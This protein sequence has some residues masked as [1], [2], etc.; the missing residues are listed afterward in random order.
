MPLMIDI[1]IGW[2]KKRVCIRSDI[3]WFGINTVSIN[4][5]LQIN[6]SLTNQTKYNFYCWRQQQQNKFCAAEVMFGLD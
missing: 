4:F 2:L 3:V 6:K 1:L 5:E